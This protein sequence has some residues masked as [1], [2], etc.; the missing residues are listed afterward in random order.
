MT[1]ANEYSAFLGSGFR[2]G[3]LGL[4]H[5][6]I[7]KERLKQESGVE[8]LLTMPRV[9]YKEENGRMFEPYMVLTIFTPAVYVGAVMTVAQNK[10]G[11]LLDIS[12]HKQNADFKI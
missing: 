4:L 6:E 1:V 2:V 5:A 10:K 3:F 11:N 7:V 9:L 12:Y 8:P